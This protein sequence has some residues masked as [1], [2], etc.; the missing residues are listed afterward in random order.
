M[1]CTAPLGLPKAVMAGTTSS[2]VT[3]IN[4]KVPGP[5]WARPADQALW[6]LMA[7]CLPAVPIGIH[8][9]WL[10]HERLSQQQMYRACY[11]LLVVTSL[12]LLWDGVRGY[13]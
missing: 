9:G 8:A 11:G 4:G 5:C 2:V 13:L 12:K 6:I 1:P 10:L 7:L 3:A